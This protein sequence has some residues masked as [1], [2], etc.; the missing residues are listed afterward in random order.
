MGQ[1]DVVNEIFNQ[2]GSFRPS[3]F[4]DVLGED[5]VRIAFEAAHAADPDAV[6]Y[7][8][9]YNLQNPTWGQLK[10]GVVPHVT[11]WV[12]AGIPIHG[13][14]ETSPTPCTRHRCVSCVLYSF[15]LFLTQVCF[16]RRLAVPPE[17]RRRR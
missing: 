5:F 12:Q 3:V 2:N 17:T 10:V 1:K 16:L 8:N 9:D 4:Y 6:L 14:G 15:V 11:K 13:I 7:Y